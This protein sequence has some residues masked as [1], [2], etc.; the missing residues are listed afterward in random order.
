MYV[1]CQNTFKFTMDAPPLAY[2]DWD[3]G[4]LLVFELSWCPDFSDM[5][6]TENCVHGLG[7]RILFLERYKTEF[8]CSLSM[9]D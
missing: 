1:T 7:V 2:P 5:Y 9:G 6:F 8:K 4:A 3:S